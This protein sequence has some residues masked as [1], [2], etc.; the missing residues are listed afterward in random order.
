MGAALDRDCLVDDIAFHA[1]SRGQAHL[2]TTHLAD[3]AAID[4][5]I[6]CYA[7]ALYGCTFA[8]GQKMRTNVTLDTALDLSSYRERRDEHA[9]FNA[10]TVAF[11]W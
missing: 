6:V 4:D 7:F 1:C 3:N 5:H 11:L 9:A 8:N 2:Q 10:T